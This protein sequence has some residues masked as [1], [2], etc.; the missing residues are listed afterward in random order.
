M[1]TKC[2]HNAHVCTEEGT[3]RFRGGPQV[4][5]FVSGGSIYSV[6]GTIILNGNFSKKLCQSRAMP[7]DVICYLLPS[8]VCCHG[9]LSWSCMN[10][11]SISPFIVPHHM[12]VFCYSFYRVFSV[13]PRAIYSIMYPKIYSTLHLKLKNI[14]PLIDSCNINTPFFMPWWLEPICKG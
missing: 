2:K 11:N 4:L 8:L 7:K 5:N 12:F 10:S 6:R 13:S 9:L 1:R 3:D 14:A